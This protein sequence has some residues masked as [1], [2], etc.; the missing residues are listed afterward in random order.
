MGWL[1]AAIVV[2][3]FPYFIVAIFELEK[4]ITSFNWPLFLSVI[5]YVARFSVMPFVFGKFNEN[6]KKAYSDLIRPLT[7][8]CL[9]KTNMNRVCYNNF[10]CCC[11]N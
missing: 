4:P 1:T 8:K 11:K 5:L 10:A 2:L 7:P 6:A 3:R 9:E